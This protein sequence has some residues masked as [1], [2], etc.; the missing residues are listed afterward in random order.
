MT[1]TW[2]LRDYGNSVIP[3]L[4]HHVRGNSMVAVSPANH[5]DYLIAAGEVVFHI[6]ARITWREPS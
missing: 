2:R 5:S 3:A 1:F 6:S 4:R